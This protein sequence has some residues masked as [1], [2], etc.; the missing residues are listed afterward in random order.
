MPETAP[1][2]DELRKPKDFPRAQCMNSKKRGCRCYTQQ[3]SLMRDYPRE[4]CLARVR[5]GY[6]DPTRQA[7]GDQRQARG[8]GESDEGARARASARQALSAAATAQ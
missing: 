2:Y 4:V 3:G 6:F 7:P 1:A 5:D 8:A